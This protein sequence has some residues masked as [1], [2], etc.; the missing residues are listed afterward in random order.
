MQ[1]TDL[2]AVLHMVGGTAA[3]FMIFVLPGLMLVNAAI[4]KGPAGNLPSEAGSS[5]AGPLGHN[6]DFLHEVLLF[7]LVVVWHE[8]VLPLVVLQNLI[9]YCCSPD[10]LL[11]PR[12][13]MASGGLRWGSR[14]LASNMQTSAFMSRC[15]IH[16]IAR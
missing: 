9:A 6:Q 5:P 11:C 13:G 16:F 4:V 14:G 8:F 3:S 7:E 12:H 10:I 1:V 2:G 15:T